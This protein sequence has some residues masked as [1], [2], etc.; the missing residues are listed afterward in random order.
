MLPHTLTDRHT[1]YIFCVPLYGNGVSS[2][3]SIAVTVNNSDPTAPSI[4]IPANNATVSGT[5]QVLDSAAPPDTRFVLY[6]GSPNMPDQPNIATATPTYYGEL[7]I[8]DTTTVPNGTYMLWSTTS[9]GQGL[10]LSAPIT[11][12]VAN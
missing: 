9:R 6:G 4:L 7:A 1:Y 3:Q 12:T 2:L 11:L 8:W 10:A 5:Q